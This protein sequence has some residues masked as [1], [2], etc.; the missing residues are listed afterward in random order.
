[1][2]EHFAA[3]VTV[4]ILYLILFLQLLCGTLYWVD[5]EIRKLILTVRLIGLFP[6]RTSAE[7]FLT[8]VFQ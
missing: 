5:E 8:P 2:A 4:S 7:G 6:S 3:R 1:M